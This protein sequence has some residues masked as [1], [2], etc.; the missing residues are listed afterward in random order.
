MSPGEHEELCHELHRDRAWIK[1]VKKAEK[2]KLMS[3][4]PENRR[5]YLE[6]RENLRQMFAESTNIAL[7]VEPKGDPFWVT[8]RKIIRDI[9]D[10]P[11]SVGNGENWLAKAHEENAELSKLKGEFEQAYPNI[12]LERG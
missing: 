10:Q 12:R 5:E 4:S 3:M 1:N 9:E 2:R 11:M 8:T 7:A 6:E